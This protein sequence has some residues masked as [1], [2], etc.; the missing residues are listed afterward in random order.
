MAE[1]MG[2][3]TEEPTA[4][5]LADARLRGQ[6]GKSADMSAFVVMAGGT[7]AVVL[8]GAGVMRA[9]ADIA[10]FVLRPEVM[11]TDLTAGRV[12]EDLKGVGLELAWFLGPFMLIMAFVGAV[13][14][15][16]Q[17]GFVFAP[18][19][20]EP[21]LSKL[22]P[23]SGFKRLF[24]KRSVVKGGLD[25]LKLSALMTVAGLVIAGDWEEVLALASLPL[26]E[27]LMYA[28]GLMIELA[29]WVLLAMLVL[30][31][32]DLV[33]QK[34]QHKDELK[35]TKHEVKDERKNADGDMEM[36]ARRMRFAREIAMQRLQSDVPQADVVITNP[37]HYA[38]AL[39]YDSEG[40]Q[41]PKVVAKGA[42]YLAMKI[43]YIATAHGVPIVERPPLA[44]ALYASVDVGQ[45]I[46][47]EQYEA[48]AE[49]L[50]YVYR[51]DREAA[52]TP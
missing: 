40:M 28:V 7:V 45:E 10:G 2:E 30:G 31:L 26:Y 6:V 43:R 8:F 3:K 15:I 4:K 44:R 27:A 20:L 23:L 9:M 33:Y 47:T 11:G 12:G 35:M 51:L 24:S 36:K 29:A 19:A 52:A 13:G 37:T 1:D 14:H 16:L 5:K 32:L 17:T 25:L 50:A 39:K 18:K 22:N 46:N 49:V 42:D 38:V 21:K 34:W 41:A 48:V